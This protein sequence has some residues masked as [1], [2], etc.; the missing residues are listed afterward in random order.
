VII[1]DNDDAL[2]AIRAGKIDIMDRVSNEQA[3]EIRKTNPEIQVICNPTTQA[4]TVQPRNDKAP[5]N[6]IR[7]RKAMQMALDLISIAREHY[8][9]TI[10]PNPSSVLSSHLSKVMKGWGFPY[11]EWPQDLKDE[12]AYNPD[13]ARQLLTDANFPKGFK[14]NIIVD[15]GSDMKLFEIIKNSFANIGIEMEVCLMETNACTAFVEARKYDQLVFRQYGPL[16][17]CYAP[18]QAI[19]RFRSGASNNIVMV[20]DPVY[21]AFYPKALAAASEDEFKKI[22]KAMC[23][24]VARQ[25]YA[26]SLLQ[27]LEYALCQPWLKG[28]H[29]QIHSVWMGVGGPSRLS[30]YGS[31]F[32]DRP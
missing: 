11:E 7:V 28:Y 23:E 6:D 12:Y 26:I 31:R 24:H 15:T 29:G 32:L 22:M 4:V 27:P 25:H 16:G 14:T 1:H 5:F 19:T 30:F 9:G 13:A 18:F 2:D 21:D 8:P 20:N 17:H 10:S 3:E